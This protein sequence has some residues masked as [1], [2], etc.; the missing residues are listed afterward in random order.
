MML[1][2]SLPMERGTLAGYWR[3]HGTE[4]EVTGD[5]TQFRDMNA[6]WL[7][8]WVL[9]VFPDSAIRDTALNIALD[10]QIRGTGVPRNGEGNDR[11]SRLDFPCNVLPQYRPALAARGVSGEFP[12]QC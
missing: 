12:A 10:Y 11:Y 7:F 9:F 6:E 5:S 4:F 8:R 2:K 1:P 3:T